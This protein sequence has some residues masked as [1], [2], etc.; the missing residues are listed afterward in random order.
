MKKT[1]EIIIYPETLNLIFHL[2]KGDCKAYEAVESQDWTDECR[3]FVIAA[4]RERGLVVCL[5]KA[6]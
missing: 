1:M 5:C 3:S 2:L 4:N 6:V